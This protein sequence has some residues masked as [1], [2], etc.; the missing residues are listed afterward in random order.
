[1]IIVSSA[2]N[3]LILR[4][5]P[6]MSTEDKNKTEED[7]KDTF[8]SI[9]IIFGVIIGIIITWIISSSFK[10]DLVDNLN[11]MQADAVRYGYAKYVPSQANQPQ[12]TWVIPPEKAKE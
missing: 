6:N 1:M 4:R 8:Y 3:H 2:I 7:R 12:F 5:G 10:Q 11:K 9:A